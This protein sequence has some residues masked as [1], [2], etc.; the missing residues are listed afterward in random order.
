MIN[1]IIKNMKTAVIITF[2]FAS[3]SASAQPDITGYNSV[4]LGLYFNHLTDGSKGKDT[5]NS[6]ISN[7][8]GLTM[9][10]MTGSLIDAI[11]S[12]KK[13]HKFRF[14]DALTIGVGAGYA[15]E[16]GYDEGEAVKNGTINFRMWAG[17]GAQASYEY[18]DGQIAG[19]RWVRTS[20]EMGN[21][22]SE[23]GVGSGKSASY[24]YHK[25]GVF[26]VFKNLGY[27]VSYLMNRPTPSI[28]TSGV[29]YSFHGFDLKAK[30]IVSEKFY[31]SAH[32]ASVVRE[33]SL[34]GVIYGVETR[35]KT[36]SFGGGISLW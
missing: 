34:Y 22:Y 17:Y 9:C 36:F 19:I 1:K 11:A 7:S 3:I 10:E 21:F 28:E 30:Y 25:I 20:E 13:R 14:G 26:G 27:E 2:L 18:G 29:D 4:E 24:G 5:K 32:Y 6:F 23:V 35:A 8:F 33:S 15:S 31:L 16:K 12:A